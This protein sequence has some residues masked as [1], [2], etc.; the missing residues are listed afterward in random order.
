[1]DIDKYYTDCD[2]NLTERCPK[3]FIINEFSVTFFDNK[4]ITNTHK[5]LTLLT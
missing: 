2:N 1:M 5:L 3:I 4:N